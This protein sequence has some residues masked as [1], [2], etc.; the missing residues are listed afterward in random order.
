MRMLLNTRSLVFAV[1]AA[2]ALGAAAGAGRAQVPPED[3]PRDEDFCSACI[4]DACD[5][6]T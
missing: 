4:N 6:A 5:N 3:E 1:C 2:C